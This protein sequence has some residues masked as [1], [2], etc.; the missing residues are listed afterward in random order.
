MV[1]RWS[2]EAR[3]AHV[4]GVV[5]IAIG[6]GGAGA[7]CATNSQATARCAGVDDKWFFTEVPFAG[8]IDC[9][10]CCQNAGA[11]SGSFSKGNGCRCYGAANEPE[12]SE[13]EPGPAPTSSGGK[14]RPY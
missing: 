9:S 7:G 1:H 2:L 6:T 3:V 5:L 4:A 8:D 14:W 12:N 11:D 13:R 10:V